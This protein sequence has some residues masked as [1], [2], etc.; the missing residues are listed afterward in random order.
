LGASGCQ[1]VPQRVWNRVGGFGTFRRGLS[2]ASLP[3]LT[4]LRCP[5]Q[6]EIFESMIPRCSGELGNLSIQSGGSRDPPFAWVPWAREWLGT[7][8][9]RSNTWHRRRRRWSEEKRR[10]MSPRPPCAHDQTGNTCSAVGLRWHGQTTLARGAPVVGV[11]SRS[12]GYGS[13]APRPADGAGAL[14]RH[15]ARNEVR[16]T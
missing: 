14:W 1:P 15:G 8:T 10:R 2:L 4:A 6:C 16:Q 3:T 5:G 7:T 11:P 9:S 12:D 13:V